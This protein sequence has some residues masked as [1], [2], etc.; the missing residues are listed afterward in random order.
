MGQTSYVYI[1]WLVILVAGLWLI[2][3]FG[4]LLHAREDFA[5]DWDLIPEEP[6]AGTLT[7]H[8]KIEQSG[9]YLR[10][11]LPEDRALRVRIID[12]QT[13]DNR[14]ADHKRV[15]L[16][17]DGAKATFEGRSRGDL[18][19]FSLEGAVHGEFVAHLT[20]RTYPRPAPA[21]QKA[22]QGLVHAR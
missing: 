15:I 8:M 1:L 20:D 6:S 3:S 2:L 17:G 19:R 16:S 12:E 10:I 7:S 22:S 5:G 11:T 18:W 13:I 9:R 14:F 4:S 21:T